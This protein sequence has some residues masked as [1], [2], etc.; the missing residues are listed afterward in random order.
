MLPDWQVVDTHD[1]YEG[2]L[3]FLES[4]S[5]V[6]G[7]LCVTAEQLLISFNCLTDNASQR[8]YLISVM[9]VYFYVSVYCINL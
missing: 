9:F 2:I 7:I 8:A 3:F 4:S 6:S 1:L 5:A